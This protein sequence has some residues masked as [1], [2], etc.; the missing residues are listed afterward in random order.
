M[1]DSSDSEIE[2]CQN[3][4]NRALNDERQGDEEP[5]PH[6]ETERADSPL[7]EYDT[8]DEE[9]LAGQDRSPPSRGY[10]DD[11]N[12]QRMAQAMKFVQA[13]LEGNKET[14]STDIK[15]EDFDANAAEYMFGSYIEEDIEIYKEDPSFAINKEQ[16]RIHY[17]K[18]ILRKKNHSRGERMYISYLDFA[19][20]ST[21]YS[22]HQVFMSPSAVYVL[23]VDLSVDFNKKISDRLN[24]RTGIIKDC[25]VA[26]SLMFWISSIKAFTSDI[27]GGRAPVLVVGTYI[28][29][30]K[31]KAV[32]KNRDPEKIIS[33]KFDEVREILKMSEIECIAINNADPDTSDLVALKNRILELGLGVI[34]EE[35]PAQW[36]DLEHR[37]QEQKIRGTAI[38]TFS[39][40]KVLDEDMD[41]PMKDNARLEAFLGHQH[42]RGHLI[43][44][45]HDDLRDLIILEPDVLA[46]FLN[47]LMRS[48]DSDDQR[49]LKQH[50]SMYNHN[51]IINRNYVTETAKMMTENV[52][53]KD[54]VDKLLN[55]LI[56]L[57]VIRPYQLENG[58]ERF[59]LP[60]LLPHRS[61]NQLRIECKK[62]R[63]LQVVFPNNHM[64]PTFYHILVGGLLDEW[65]PV[66]RNV[67]AP[68]I[69]N[70]Y[71]CFQLGRETHQMEI[72]WKESRI[73]ID[74]L[75]YSTR[76][77]LTADKIFKILE[78]VE[79]R[80]EQIFRVYRHTNK[81]Y[82][83][84][85]SCP[86]HKDSFASVSTL[87]NDG[88]AMCYNANGTHSVAF[89]EVFGEK[90]SKKVCL[91]RCYLPYSTTYIDWLANTFT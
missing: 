58:D 6:I 17:M 75:N 46:K 62:K 64:P 26:E 83:I 73:Y 21:Y 50:T 39:D 45:L 85:I 77:T 66:Q 10:E 89:E 81:N 71:A 48:R 41:V 86:K 57:S 25:S 59:L 82:E 49:G 27:K 19:G 54:N 18:K 33:Q 40:L 72:Y 7:D 36:I 61:V 22:T 43:Y 3:N 68:E 13:E 2:F 60:C 51:G 63:N 88:E 55:M 42:N 87:R 29:K 35:I 15:E 4:N 52:E 30:V 11:L 28:D 47:N 69:Y 5:H 67:D 23:V 24:F 1:G 44:F 65:N 14:K 32:K 16:S 38:M 84:R 70:L 79:K 12:V 31:L 37:I 20:Q 91:I 80:I 8:N 74:L 78:I 90:L 76:E 56:H 53:M 34:D 9:P